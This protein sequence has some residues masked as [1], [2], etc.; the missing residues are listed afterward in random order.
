MTSLSTST[1][2]RLAPRRSFL[3]VLCRIVNSQA[4]RF[5]PSRNVGEK[6]TALR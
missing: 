6:R 4:F 1:G 2:W 3:K 5:V